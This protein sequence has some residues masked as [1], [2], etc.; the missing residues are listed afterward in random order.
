[1]SLTFLTLIPLLLLIIWVVAEF[2]GRVWIRITMGI[3][4][5]VT[6]AVMAFL[7]GGFMEAFNH[8]EFPAPHDSPTQATL[9]DAA[10]QSATN[11]VSK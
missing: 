6:I 1:M 4:T 2:R 5:L 3:A 9:M 7:W 8:T 10:D 11:G